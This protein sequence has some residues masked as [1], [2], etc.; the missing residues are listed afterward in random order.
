MTW[1]KYTIGLLLILSS[2]EASSL[3]EIIHSTLENNENIKASM[4]ESRSKGKLY[5]SVEN[6]YKVLLQGLI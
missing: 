4:L 6:I 2:L 3:K 5:D 1:Y